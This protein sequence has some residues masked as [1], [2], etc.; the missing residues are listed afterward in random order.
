MNLHLCPDC[1]SNYTASGAGRRT[2][3]E[4]GE[5]GSRTWP[6]RLYTDSPTRKC[7]KHRVQGLADGAARR[8]GLDRAT[9][10]WAD[11]AAIHAVYDEAL[12]LTRE[13]SVRA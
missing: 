1:L 8:A 7:A 5:G 2:R 10:P 9:P 3:R 6:A 13:T 12:R 4:G 11:R